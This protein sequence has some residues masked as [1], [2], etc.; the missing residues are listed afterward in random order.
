M[1][2]TV[3]AVLAGWMTTGVFVVCFDLILRK[4]IPNDYRDGQIP[5]DAVT[6][7]VLATSCLFSIP[8]GWVTAKLAKVDPARHVVYLILWGLLMGIVSAIGSW[9]QIQWWYQIGLIILW[10][11][12][13]LLGGRLAMKGR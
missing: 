13:V 3:L 8:A 2:R 6:A 10:A 5:P 1:L 11:P 7:L 4:A 9:G 12:M